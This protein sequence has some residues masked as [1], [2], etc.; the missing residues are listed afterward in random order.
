MN[1]FIKIVA[2]L[3]LAFTAALPAQSY[4]AWDTN[5]YT[6]TQISLSDWAISKYQTGQKL[7]TTGFFNQSE[8]AYQVVV[9]E[10]YYPMYL[11]L[12]S[13]KN[14]IGYS[15]PVNTWQLKYK[16]LCPVGHS[17]LVKQHIAYA[18]ATFLPYTYLPIDSGTNVGQ[19]CN[20]TPPANLTTLATVQGWY[21]A[22]QVTRLYP[23]EDIFKVECLAGACNPLQPW[24]D[25]TGY[26]MYLSNNTVIG[27]KL[28]DSSS[29]LRVFVRTPD[30]VTDQT[31]K[32]D[33][34]LLGYSY[35]GGYVY[36]ISQN[37]SDATI[38]W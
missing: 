35:F 1:K 21:P 38:W 12:Y 18:A 20:Y 30:T 6:S 4:A 3:V 29:D 33:I 36:W 25:I 22:Y 16:L 9:H 14:L 5:A 31:A 34:N 13:N 37:Q 8:P 26:T 15:Q 32:D 17:T 27:R 19:A 2:S 28:Q 10:A 24:M 7:V 23:N 11:Y